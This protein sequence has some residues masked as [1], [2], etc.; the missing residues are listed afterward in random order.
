MGRAVGAPY[1]QAIEADVAHV[2]EVVAMQVPEAV[3]IHVLNI[4]TS[5][6]CTLISCSS[7]K[8]LSMYLVK[9]CMILGFFWCRWM[10]CRNS[11]SASP[12]LFLKNPNRL[13]NG[14]MGWN[15]MA[16]WCKV[17]QLGGFCNEVEIAGESFSS[18]ELIY[19]GLNLVLCRWK[20]L[21]ILRAGDAWSNLA[22]HNA[23]YHYCSLANHNSLSAVINTL[24]RAYNCTTRKTVLS[25]TLLHTEWCW[26]ALYCTQRYKVV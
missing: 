15:K 10:F 16:M 12:W 13:K 4:A 2:L 21:L 17:W 20:N 6:E 1:C 14:M 24:L 7:K 26:T 3:V 8:Y 18:T 19:V 22:L 9:S 11:A 23:G 25:S 5:L